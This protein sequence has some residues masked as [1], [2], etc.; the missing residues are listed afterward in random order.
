MC[1]MRVPT[2]SVRRPAPL[3]PVGMR[4]ASCVANRRADCPD[5]RQGAG[6]NVRVPRTQTRSTQLGNHPC[7]A[8]SRMRVEHAVVSPH[9]S[10]AFVLPLG[11]QTK[12]VCLFALAGTRR[13][14]ST[15]YLT[16]SAS[17]RHAA[18]PGPVLAQTC[19]SS[20]C[21]FWRG[22]GGPGADVAVLHAAPVRAVRT[23][24]HLLGASNRPPRVCLVRSRARTC[25]LSNTTR[26][27][28]APVPE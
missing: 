8:S 25:A 17:S 12:A 2:T 6:R 3:P 5:R 9:P 11:A 21:R 27:Q 22:S 14:S 4:R 24:L 20:A 28:A 1:G 18:G 16:R 26:T 13:R 10:A 19:A 15:C 23:R 7:A